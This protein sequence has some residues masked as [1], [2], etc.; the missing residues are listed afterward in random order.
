MYKI[1]FLDKSKDDLDE[2][3]F[4]ISED[5]PDRA[6]KMVNTIL[7][8]V[9]QLEKFPHSG[10]TVAD[11]VEVKGDYRMIVVNPYLVFYRVIKD[12]IFIYRVL[13]GKRFYQ[14]LLEECQR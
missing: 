12:D 11:K 6:E 10:V 2:I 9:E 8:R 5:S 7:E 3:Y 1:T 13:H 14:A 4:Y